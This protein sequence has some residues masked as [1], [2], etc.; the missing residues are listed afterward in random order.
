MPQVKRAMTTWVTSVKHATTDR[1]RK[2][3]R[4]GVEKLQ[5]RGAS[6]KLAL[7]NELTATGAFQKEPDPDLLRYLLE[8][9]VTDSPLRVTLDTGET[10]SSDIEM[11][12]T[13]YPLR[14]R[15]FRHYEQQIAGLPDAVWEWARTLLLFAQYQGQRAQPV[16]ARNRRLAERYHRL[17][18]YDVLW[19]CCYDL[20][21]PLSLA[22]LHQV[23][24]QRRA[25]P[26]PFL[27]YQAWQV[28]EATARINTTL[29]ASQLL[30]PDGDRLAYLRNEVG[31]AYQ[32]HIYSFTLDLPFL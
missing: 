19:G 32:E 7:I 17:T 15:A 23:P 21:T 8:P 25:D 28:G 5:G 4:K 1:E 24:D 26:L 14:L 9:V 3:V 13:L 29:V 6:G 22:A 18:I 12:A 2:E 20:L 27:H 16:L 30:L 11:L 31:I 10:R